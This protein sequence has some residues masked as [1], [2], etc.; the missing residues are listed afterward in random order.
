MASEYDVIISGGMNP[1]LTKLEQEL[2]I[3]VV[4]CSA[5]FLLN[6][7][8][9]QYIFKE[10]WDAPAIIRFIATHTKWRKW[11]SRQLISRLFGIPIDDLLAL[12]RPQSSTLNIVYTSRYFQPEEATFD[13]K[14][15]FIGPTP[16][17]TPHLE[18]FLTTG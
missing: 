9:F 7:Q 6:E 10:T 14:C 3:P 11:L 12:F 2:S 18:L 17:I 1:L 4:Y 13:E 8:S 15:L 5:T 16:T